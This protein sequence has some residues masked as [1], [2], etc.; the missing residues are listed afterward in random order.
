MQPCGWQRNGRVPIL[1]HSRTKELLRGIVPIDREL[2][3]GET[4]DIGQVPHRSLSAQRTLANDG[5]AH[6]GSRTRA[7]S[8]FW[9]S[10]YRVLLV[11]DMISMLSSVVILHP[12]GNLAHYLDSL[13]LLLRYPARLLLPAH[14]SPT[15]RCRH[16]LEEAVR[17][18]EIRENQLLE[19]L[20]S[21]RRVPFST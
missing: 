1:A 10:T 9:D 14:G 21:I 19:M 13:R 11:G 6:S 17:H 5:S 16:V 18:R 15:A 4:L 8:Y 7:I 3:D 2:Q 20:S 12:E